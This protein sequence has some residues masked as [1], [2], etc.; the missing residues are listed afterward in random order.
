MA[1]KYYYCIYRTTNNING[2]TYIGQHRYTNEENPL[3]CYK[4]SGK[5]IKRALVKYG[6]SNF[7]TEILYKRIQ[8]QETADDLEIISIKRER[9][10]GKAEYNILDGGQG[11]RDYFGEHN[12]MYGKKQSELSKELNRQKHLGKKH[13]EESKKKMSMARVGENNGRYGKHWTN[14][15]K[16]MISIKT[17][18]GM[19]D[20]SIIDKISLGVSLAWTKPEYIE[21]QRIAHQYRP[22]HT[23]EAKQKMSNARKDC[24][25]ITN[26]IEEMLQ[27]DF[28]PIPQGWYRGRLTTGKMIQ[29]VDE[30]GKRHRI[31]KDQP[32]PQGWHRGR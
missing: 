16:E 31:S 29:V 21:K 14:E 11:K 28:L 13:T 22:K 19:S 26:G 32:I 12:P 17:K 5:L 15:Q 10:L 2:K 7:S 4:G 20:Q 27:K 8:L 23:D 9:L 3:G 25:W 24:I 1:N 18:Q 30:N 6:V